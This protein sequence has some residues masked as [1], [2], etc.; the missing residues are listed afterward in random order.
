MTEYGDESPV[1]HTLFELCND[2]AQMR[3]FYSD[4]LGLAET[5]FNAEKGWLT[6]QAGAVQVVFTE[7]RSAPAR[8]LTEW[9]RSPGWDGGTVDEPSWV[10]R[11]APGAF[12]AL[13]DRLAAHE[14]DTQVRNAPDGR[15]REVFV[16]DPMGRTVEIYCEY[17]ASG[18]TQREA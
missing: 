7:P 6:Y 8:Q 16:M 15:L 12:D 13:L 10:L 5:M 4:A 2:V 3:S 9:S 14:T 18:D 17:D 1:M 11:I